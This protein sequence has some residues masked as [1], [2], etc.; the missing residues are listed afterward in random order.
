LIERNAAEPLEDGIVLPPPQNGTRIRVC[1]FEPESAS[2]YAADRQAT[3][4][5]FDKV[6]GHGAYSGH[7]NGAH[8]MMH[9]T[10][11]VDYGIVL[12][13]EI[14]LVLEECETLVR[15]GDIV[16]QVGTNHA[17]SNR[18]NKICRVAFVLVDGKFDAGLLG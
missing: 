10:E 15:A 14:F 2:I 1:D 7:K 12:E 13:G 17:W 4:A 8:P 11:T 18:S 5:E 3:L 6:G 16:I 9:R